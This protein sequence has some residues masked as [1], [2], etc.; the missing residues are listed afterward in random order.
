MMYECN[1]GAAGADNQYTVGAGSEPL[2]G[3][4]YQVE[5]EPRSNQEIHQ[6]DCE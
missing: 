6:E 5:R 1:S 4:P 2:H 3:A